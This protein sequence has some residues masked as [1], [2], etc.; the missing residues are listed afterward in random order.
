MRGARFFK[1]RFGTTGKILSDK[2]ARQAMFHDKNLTLRARFFKD[3]FG[4]TGKIL[5]DNGTIDN[6]PLIKNLE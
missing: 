1:A 4:T 2:L 5:L 3:K 6:I